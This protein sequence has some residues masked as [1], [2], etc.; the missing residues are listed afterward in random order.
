MQNHAPYIAEYPGIVTAD[1]LSRV[2]TEEGLPKSGGR[3]P[4]MTAPIAVLQAHQNVLLHVHIVFLH[5]H[6]GTRSV[7]ATRII[8]R[9]KP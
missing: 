6:L 4:D 9:V 8:V 3:G 1:T 7:L 5:F 2:L